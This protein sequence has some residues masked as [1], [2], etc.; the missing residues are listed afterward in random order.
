MAEA[1]QIIAIDVNES[2]FDLARELGA[3]DCINPRDTSSWS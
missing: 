1:K 2:K 3:T